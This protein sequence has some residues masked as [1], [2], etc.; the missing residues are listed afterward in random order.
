MNDPIFEVCVGN[1]SGSGFK[2]YKIWANG[3]VHGF[4]DGDKPVLI[5]NRIPLEVVKALKNTAKEL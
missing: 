4:E 3:Q 1:P 2:K 5:I